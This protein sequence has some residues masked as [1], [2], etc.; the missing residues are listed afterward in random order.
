LARVILRPLQLHHEF[1]YRNLP[2]CG[3]YV[4]DVSLVSAQLKRPQLDD[5]HPAPQCSDARDETMSCNAVHGFNHVVV[6][7]GLEFWEKAHYFDYEFRQS[8]EALRC[9][10][11]GDIKHGQPD[12]V[13]VFLGRHALNRSHSALAVKAQHN[14]CIR[15]RLKHSLLVD[16]VH[17]LD[18][19]ASQVFDTALDLCKKRV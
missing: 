14:R 9:I 3:G 15:E 7:H 1:L 2:L 12:M 17:R 11:R 8:H 10:C 19:H 16:K 13:V 5:L 6:A 18:S 4:D